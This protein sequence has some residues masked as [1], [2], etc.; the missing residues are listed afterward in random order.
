MR[1]SPDKL[2]VILI[3]HRVEG[4]LKGSQVV[5]WL[6]SACNKGLSCFHS[7][8]WLHHR[9]PIG[10][11]QVRNLVTSDLG[12]GVRRILLFPSPV[13]TGKSQINCKMAK[14]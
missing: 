6:Q 7:A 5:Y 3:W 8:M 9:R 2:M 14:K 12:C 1:E 11:G 13:T 10:T 4:W